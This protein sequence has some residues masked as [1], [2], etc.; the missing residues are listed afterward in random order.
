MGETV[1]Y[2]HADGVAWIT[3]DDGKVNALSPS[4][5]AEVHAAL[6]DAEADDAV[7]VLRGRDGVFSAGF[8]LEVLQRA[9]A[10]S[11]AMV[12]GGFELARRVLAFPRPVITACTGHAVAMGLFLLQ[13]GDHR[14]GTEGGAKLVANEVVIGLSVPQPAIEL[15]SLRVNPAALPRVALGQTFTPEGALAAGLVDEL[16]APDQYEARLAEVAAAFAALDRSAVRTTKARLRRGALERLDAAI[17]AERQA[18]D[19]QIE[20]AGAER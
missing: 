11:A 1:R 18:F 6:D 9:N 13:S 16:A 3:I 4:T 19:A 2:E 5:Q 20:A 15:L 14:L 8:D 10:D 17:A 7:V 12:V